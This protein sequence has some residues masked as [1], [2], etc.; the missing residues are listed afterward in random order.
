MVGHIRD[1]ICLTI[2]TEDKYTYVHLQQNLFESTFCYCSNKFS[3]WNLIKYMNDL[4]LQIG[5]KV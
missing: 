1:E 3:V 4:K 5:S 2:E